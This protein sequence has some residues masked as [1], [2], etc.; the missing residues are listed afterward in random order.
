[1]S[2]EWE[3]VIRTRQPLRKWY[4]TSEEWDELAERH[5][6]ILQA[7]HDY[8]QFA[9]VKKWANKYHI[10][11]YKQKL[12]TMSEEYKDKYVV[13]ELDLSLIHI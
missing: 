7:N 5:S 4:F 10:E 1:M 2:S 12:L 8:V 13:S 3:S 6:F 11:K 9:S